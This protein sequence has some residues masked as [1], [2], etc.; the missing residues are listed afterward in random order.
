MSSTSGSNVV[1]F[2]GSLIPD[3]TLARFLSDV[4]G[5]L[6]EI[7]EWHPVVFWLICLA[8]PNFA[9]RHLPLRHAAEKRMARW[10]T[11]R[12]NG[13]RGDVITLNWRDELHSFGGRP[14]KITF[15]LTGVQIPV[16]KYYWH[17]FGE[18]TLTV[19]RFTLFHL[20][21]DDAATEELSQ[22]DGEATEE[23]CQVLG[24]GRDIDAFLTAQGF[25][26]QSRVPIGEYLKR[27]DE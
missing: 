17:R 7:A 16:K 12:S 27:M 25:T 3:T 18:P 24:D 14:S 10:M 23:I 4:D 26:L 5:L 8:V 2:D 9:R 19:S 21:V 20:V 6:Y 11:R 22:W 1:L 13:A 15:S